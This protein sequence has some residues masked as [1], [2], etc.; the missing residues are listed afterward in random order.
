MTEIAFHF[1]IPQRDRYLCQLLRKATGKGHSVVVLA[2]Q[3]QHTALQTALHTLDTESFISVC[4]A[5]AQPAVLQRS[6]VVFSDAAVPTEPSIQ[7]PHHDVLINLLDNI[8]QGFERYAKVIELVEERAN[9]SRKEAAREKWRY[10]SDRGYRI[11]RFD[12]GRKTVAARPT[13]PTH[14]PARRQAH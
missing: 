10:Y 1:N 2:P 9:S 14:P 12:L 5:N 3:T 6:Q 4:A 11:E 13:L 7:M 8:S